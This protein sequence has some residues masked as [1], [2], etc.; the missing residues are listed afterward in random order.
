MDNYCRFANYL[1]RVFKSMW[2][3]PYRPDRPFIKILG[4]LVT[5]DEI[6]YA[7]QLDTTPISAKELADKLKQ[8]LLKVETA[9][10]RLADRGVIIS[11]PKN[12]VLRYNLVPQAPGI[13]E[14]LM[15]RDIMDSDIARW[16][17]EMRDEHALNILPD[18]PP[19]SSN[20]RVIPV[21]K[22][23]AADPRRASFDEIAIYLEKSEL[24][25]VCDCLC[26]A[27]KGE[28]GEACG[29][30]MGCCI[31]IGPY[32]D[33][34]IR[35]GRS[36]KINKREVLELLERT[37]KAGLIHQV[38]NNEGTGWSSYICSCCGCCCLSLRAATQYKIPNGVVRSSYVAEIDPGKCQKCGQCVRACQMKALSLGIDPETSCLTPDTPFDTEWTKDKWDDSYREKRPYMGDG[39]AVVDARLCAGCGACSV[40]C[41]FDAI[42][43][44]KAKEY[45]PAKTHHEGYTRFLDYINA[46]AER[47]AEKKKNG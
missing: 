43:L 41:Q 27:A 28:L 11:L 19:G 22:S 10:E 14:F 3:R 7:L 40:Q 37:S 17:D 39:P 34:Y 36:R 15:R 42:K 26:R 35:T 44:V 32:A 5:S 4:K 25:A 31:Q 38:F 16:L 45:P 23:I 30:E 8:P 1:D 12:G 2:V 13:V 47:L 20:M 18:I 24:Y 21:A 6:W 9:L 29:H 33:Y 46:R